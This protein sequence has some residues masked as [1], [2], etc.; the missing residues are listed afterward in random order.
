M[1][2]VEALCSP[3]ESLILCSPEWFSFVSLTDPVALLQ[4]S[5]VERCLGQALGAIVRKKKDVHGRLVVRDDASLA[6][7]CDSF[8]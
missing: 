4:G 7:F 1:R 8:R 5:F 6:K 2:C 3:P